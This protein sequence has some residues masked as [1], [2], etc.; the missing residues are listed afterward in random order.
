[1]S[2]DFR[3]WMSKIKQANK[4]VQY[5]DI[6]ENFKNDTFKNFIFR[7]NQIKKPKVQRVNTNGIRWSNG[8]DF[9]VKKKSTPK[10]ALPNIR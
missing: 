10:W 9:F 7:K 4:I 6:H 8:V 3:N 1:M 2:V 5:S